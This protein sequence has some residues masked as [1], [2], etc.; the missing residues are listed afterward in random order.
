MEVH[1][2]HRNQKL[3]EYC[4]K[5]G[6]HVTGYSP[7][8]GNPDY[9]GKR[10]RGDPTVIEIAKKNNKAV[11]QV[12]PF[13]E[14]YCTRCKIEALESMQLSTSQLIFSYHARRLPQPDYPLSCCH[15]HVTL[16]KPSGILG[17]IL[18]TYISYCTGMPVIVES[19]EDFQ[20]SFLH[21]EIRQCFKIG[22]Y[23]R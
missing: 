1:C 19:S 20:K 13:A 6:V 5:T 23:T 14:T 10:P 3:V 7:T 21:P 8:G 17:S 12:Q 16:S 15:L 18:D 22:D 4:H 11:N 2:W 9:S